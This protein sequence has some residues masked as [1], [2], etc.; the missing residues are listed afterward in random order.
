MFCVDSIKMDHEEEENGK[1]NKYPI[2]FNKN[3]FQTLNN[4]VDRVYTKFYVIR[5]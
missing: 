3:W 5:S 2:F 1:I 4:D